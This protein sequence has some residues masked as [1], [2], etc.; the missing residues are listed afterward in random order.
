[1]ILTDHIPKVNTAFKNVKKGG[2]EETERGKSFYGL[3][4]CNCL[5]YSI[6]AKLNRNT[7][8]G[9]TDYAAFWLT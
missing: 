2:K 3:N 4:R 5:Q 1:M 8:L 9:K 6:E 7:L